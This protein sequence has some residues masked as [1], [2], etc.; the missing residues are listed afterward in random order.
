M[1]LHVN[2]SGTW[3]VVNEVHVNNAGVWQEAQE[4]Y[5]NDAGVW[6]TIHKVITV[7]ASSA[8]LNLFSAAGSPTSPIMLKVTVNAGVT[9]SSSSTAAAALDISSFATGSYIQLINNGTI[10]GGGG[11]VGSVAAGGLTAQSYPGN[12][13]GAF[14]KPNYTNGYNGTG[15][16]TG[17]GAGGSTPGYNYYPGSPYSGGNG[18]NG[19]AG[20]AA[21]GLNCN[22]TLAIYNTA[23]IVGGGGGA[24][25]QAFNNSGGGRGGDGGYVITYAGSHPAVTAVNTSTGLIASGGGASGGWGNRY[26]GD[27]IGGR[28]GFAGSTYL[29]TGGG[30]GGSGNSPGMAANNTGTTRIASAGTYTLSPAV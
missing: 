20:G 16:P 28:P 15:Y 5:V 13:N 8:N 12:Y 22:V 14:V 19:G 27:G 24:G 23:T 3:Q 30:S 29:P 9:I 21:I 1:T 11:A 10:V 4:V 17:P 26:E 25:G 18:G 6:R 2:D 7:T